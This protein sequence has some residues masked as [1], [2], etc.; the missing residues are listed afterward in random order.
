MRCS[1]ARVPAQLC[2]H[3]CGLGIRWSGR[4]K[5][6]SL[7]S[8][9][10]FFVNSKTEN[11]CW[12]YVRW[13][14][15][16]YTAWSHL[17]EFAFI[18]NNK[19]LNIKRT[20]LHALHSNNY[21]LVSLWSHTTYMPHCNFHAGELTCVLSWWFSKNSWKIMIINSICV[22]ACTDRGEIVVVITLTITLN[23]VI[24]LL[25]SMALCYE[26]TAA[27]NVAHEL[28]TSTLI[29]IRTSATSLITWRW[30]FLKPFTALVVCWAGPL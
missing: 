23:L 26:Y 22:V 13:L 4:D 18:Q 17:Y 29:S 5:P 7:S 25:I 1:L 28:N 2:R 14:K 19:Y 11:R 30:Q 9:E 21:T 24:S 10:S 27:W 8:L 15:S 12:V 3:L 16:I 6:L 20:V